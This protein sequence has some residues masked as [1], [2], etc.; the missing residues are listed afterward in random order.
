HLVYEI[1]SNLT[2]TKAAGA[3][4]INWQSN[5]TRE[6][7]AGESTLTWNDDMYS[8]TGSASGSTSGGSTFSS[9]ITSPLIRNMSFACRRHFVQGI[10]EHT[11]SGKQTRVIDFG[12]GTCDNIALVTIGSTSYT[13]TLP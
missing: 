7:T 3:G 8:I 5:R 4:V 6:W 2:I 10:I 1:S 11:P 9:I 12:N 13:V